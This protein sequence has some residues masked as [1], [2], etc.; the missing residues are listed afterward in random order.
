[1]THGL[2]SF[3]QHGFAFGRWRSPDRRFRTS[4]GPFLATASLIWVA[5][6]SISRAFPAVGHVPIAPTVEAKNEREMNRRFGRR[7]AA[8]S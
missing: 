2:F 4:S 7:S 8:L 5:A 6:R 3:E 1:V